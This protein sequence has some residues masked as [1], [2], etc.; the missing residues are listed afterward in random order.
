MIKIEAAHEE[1]AKELLEIYRPYVE[2]SVITF[3]YDVPTVEE[4]QKRIRNIKSK[5]PYLIAKNEDVILGY[6]YASTYYNRQA[7]DWTVEVSI[8]VDEKAR[9]QGVGKR[10]YSELE[11]AL[12]NQGIK[13]CLACIALPNSA[14]IA[15]HEKLG[16]Q[17]TAHFKEVGYKFGQWHDIIWMQK[18]LR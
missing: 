11:L 10:L 9:G 2:S 13:N 16:Y 14:S 1:N 15:L 5:F 12:V 7:Y 3:E 18:K 8:Y 17:K 4:F 6:A